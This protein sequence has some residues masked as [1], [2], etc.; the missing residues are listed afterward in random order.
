MKLK[1]E[2]HVDEV[3]EGDDLSVNQVDL[4]EISGSNDKNV[5]LIV[6][7]LIPREGQI[8]HEYFAFDSSAEAYI[9]LEDMGYDIL[10]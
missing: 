10:S 1:I 4:I 3:I 9:W 8:K 6:K 2:K 7:S 5:F